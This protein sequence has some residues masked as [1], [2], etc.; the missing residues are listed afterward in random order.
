MVSANRQRTAKWSFK[1]F[2]WNLQLQWT[3]TQYQVGPISNGW[4]INVNEFQLRRW[5]GQHPGAV[6]LVTSSPLRSSAAIDLSVYPVTLPTDPVSPVDFR[7][8]SPLSQNGTRLV[9]IWISKELLGTLMFSQ[10]FRGLVLNETTHGSSDQ[11][12]LQI[13][14]NRHYSARNTTS[15]DDRQ[16][17]MII[18]PLKLIRV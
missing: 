9:L 1:E 17:R 12:S 4:H 15:K 2:V 14:K 3:V 8:P 18:Q 11:S 5:T 16:V 6:K 13:G 7:V 10:L